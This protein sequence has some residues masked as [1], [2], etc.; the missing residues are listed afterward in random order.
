MPEP[1]P[2][3]TSEAPSNKEKSEARRIAD[4]PYL[5]NMSDYDL[6]CHYT[7]IRTRISK[8]NTEGE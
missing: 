6:L 2:R 7:D 4:A 1:L 3:S 8:L 5:G